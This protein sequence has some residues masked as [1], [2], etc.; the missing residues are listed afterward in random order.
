MPL[1]NEGAGTLP[2]A[3]TEAGAVAA[4]SPGRCARLGGLL[5][6]TGFLLCL[7]GYLAVAVP[8]RWF[9]EASARVWGAAELT[10]ARGSG[11]VSGDELVVTAA[12]PSGIAIVSVSSSLRAADFPAVAWLAA[13]VADDA[14]VRLVWRTDVHPQRLNSAAITVTAGQPMPTMLA[15]DQAWVGRVTG[16]A[17]TIRAPLDKPVRIR[18]LVAKPMGAVEILRDRAREWLAFEAWTG[19]SINTVVGGADSQDLPLPP[20]AAAACA[21]ACALLLALRRRRP[22]LT[23]AAT[24]GLVLALFAA[25]WLVLDARWAW[26]LVRQEQATVGTY[27]GLTPTEKHLAAEDGALY[28]FVEQARRVMPDTPVR[29]FVVADAAYFRGRAAY[30]LY[31]HRVY[32]DRIDGTMPPAGAL[33]PGDWLANFDARSIAYDAVSGSLRWNGDQAVA[34]EPRLVVPGA[35]LFLIR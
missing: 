23:P 2:A 22:G 17:L 10:L 31:P 35:A 13:D 29:V 32:T 11:Q 20:L 3:A 25:A 34:A 6:A 28:A 19:S 4:P 5:L 26:N 33:R 12:D 1:G 7:L 24:G 9:P 18:G 27:G 21:V 14:E 15:T 16:L 8:A 30:H